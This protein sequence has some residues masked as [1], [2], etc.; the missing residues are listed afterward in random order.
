MNIHHHN[1][2]PRNLRG[3]L[4]HRSGHAHRSHAESMGA[5]DFQV[6][7]QQTSYLVLG[8]PGPMVPENQKKTWPMGQCDIPPAQINMS[9]YVQSHVES[10]ES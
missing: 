9:K 1:C 10:V 8:W 2:F 6:I 4:A 7:F 3:S 5:A